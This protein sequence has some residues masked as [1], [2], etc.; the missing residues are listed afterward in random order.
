MKLF[1]FSAAL[2]LVFFCS[3]SSQQLAPLGKLLDKA[4]ASLDEKEATLIL[5]YLK[6]KGT[7]QL[8]AISPRSL[9]SDKAIN[10]RA[11]VRSTSTLIDE[12]DLP[13]EET[14]VRAIES[15][16][17]NIR[18]R[19]KWFNAVSA[20][21]TKQQIET[22]RSL[23]F[24]REIEL[25]GRW[26]TDKELEQELPDDSPQ[27]EMNLNMVDSLNYGASYTQLNQISVP[28]V[29]N[30]GIY[31]QGVIVGSFDNGFRLPNHEVFANMNII[32]TYDF[33]DHKKSVVPN[34]PSSGFGSHGVNTLSTLGGFKEGELIGSAFGADYIIART[35]NDSSET[36]VEEDNW[37]A[38]IEWADSIG[39]DVTSTSLG[40]LTYDAP[41]TSWTWEDMDGNTTLITRAA[42]RAVELGIVV[43]NSAGNERS[44]G[45]PNTLVAP[46]DGDSVIAV[47]AVTSSGTYS[48]FSS[49]GPSSDGQTKPDIMAMGS[50]VRVASSTNPVAYGSS[51]GTSFS[52]P[53]SAGVAA[54][55]LCANPSLTP[56]QVRDALRLTANNAASP[57]NNYGWGILNARNAIGYFGIFPSIHG[58]IYND[59]DADGVK[60][61]NE[62]AVAG[63][64]VRITGTITD[65]T[66]TDAN[67]KYL[68]D[69]LSVG[70]FT[71]STDSPPPGKK[72]LF[73]SNGFYGITIDSGKLVQTGKDFSI[74]D[75]ASLTGSVFED[76]N[77]D[78][79]KQPEEPPVSGWTVKLGGSLS[80]L[81]DSSGTFTFN[82][83]EGG[84]YTLSESLQVGW[85]QTT[86]PVNHTVDINYGQE[87][88]GYSFGVFKTG[89]IQGIVF[90]DV[91]SNTVQD[92]GDAGISGWAMKLNG[93]VE[94]TA[95]TDSNGFY[96]FTN[97]TAGTYTVSETLMNSWLQTLPPDNGSYSVTI[98]SSLD[99][100]GLDFGNYYAPHLSFAVSGGWNLLSLPLE[101]EN[102][103]V[104]SVYSS[105]Q[106][107]AYTF[108]HSYIPRDTVPDD[109]GY[110]LKFSSSQNVMLIGNV[111]SADTISVT[112]GWNILGS[113]SDPVPVSSIISQ[114]ESL[115]VS[116]FYAFEGSYV[117]S[118][119]IMP[120]Q[121]YWVKVNNDGVLIL[122][123]TV[124]QKH[125]IN[126]KNVLQVR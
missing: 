15:N 48:G 78:G 125:F 122:Q 115:I 67:G 62:T 98:R 107:L 126:R 34:N 72:L 23:P 54:L 112:K 66:Y 38:A 123:S 25:V 5:I 2:L 73:P 14:Y 11:K 103:A 12:H 89:S 37:A 46:A 41:Y 119:T 69:S 53:I 64:L 90:E 32:A 35:E 95:I 20:K 19:L 80:T 3:S 93:T 42:D 29:H 114:P 85:I 26:K 124:R 92:S 113:I 31:G 27:Q 33:V 47:G 87:A 121:G 100:T 44:S 71:L 18:H 56:M 13:L 106:S 88:T 105:A 28:A 111:K 76:V 39:V 68:F 49:Y 101:I 52:C 30:L 118:D 63:A 70:N 61:T 86:S 22:L 94:A 21:A 8:A 59:L 58:A 74:V 40:Y 4:I 117:S 116:E 75:Y 1:L 81:T 65:S 77:G 6:D 10:R 97:L 57:N 84:M 7:Q 120:H 45:T 36:P 9:L 60:D 108:D 110:W 83:V 96:T 51:N 43:V 50:G 16:V 104:T 55:V 82:E 102:R 99:T 17:L 91:N 24:V 109:V 79:T